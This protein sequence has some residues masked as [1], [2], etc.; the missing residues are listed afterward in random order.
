MG[1]FGSASCSVSQYKHGKYTFINGFF[2][3]KW[4]GR[5]LHKLNS[6]Y[7]T[8]WINWKVLL[9]YNYEPIEGAKTDN[10]YSTPLLFAHFLFKFSSPSMDVFSVWI[11][12]H[13]HPQKKLCK[14]W[15]IF[16]FISKKYY[17]PK[18]IHLRSLF[19]L[20]SDGYQR[21]CYPSF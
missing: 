8:S 17:V 10:F 16:L 11:H 2:L 4:L 14:C 13:I 18:F 5:A 9:Y 7:V 21:R 1:H 6:I 15:S 20:L 19:M 12:S 3:L